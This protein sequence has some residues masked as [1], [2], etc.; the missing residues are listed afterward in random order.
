MPTLIST[1]SIPMLSPLKSYKSSLLAPP[2]ARHTVVRLGSLAA[3]AVLGMPL[4]NAQSVGDVTLSPVTVQDTRDREQQGYQGGKTRVGKTSQLA[5]DVPQSVTIV[6][7]QLIRERNA[8][9]FKEALRNVAGLTF[10]AGEGG[11]IGDNIT[12]RGYSAVGDLFLDGI[13]DIAQYNRETFNLQ[14]IDVLRGSASMLFGRGSTGGIIN[15]VSKTANMVDANEVAFTLGSDSYKRL[16][17]DM[18]KV[19][20]PDLAFRLNTMGTKS[21]SFRDDVDQSRWG[22][23]PS[24]TWRAGRD[25]EITLA[26]YYLKNNNTPDFGVPFFQGRPLN[27][28]IERFYGLRDTDYQRTET[29]IATA[30]HTHLF[31][32]DSALRTTIRKA[33]YERDLRGTAPRLIGAPT[34]VSDITGVNRQR[35]ARGGTEHTLALQTD[36]T[37]KLALAGMSHEVLLGAEFLRERALRYTNSSTIANP[38]TNVGNPNSAP[39]LPANFNASFNRTGYNKYEGRTTSVY[40]QDTIA[41]APQWKLLLG[42]RFDSMKAD[43]AR[44]LPAG[45]LERGDNVWSWRTGVMYEPTPLATWYVSYGSSFNPSAEAYQLDNRTANTPPEKSRNLEAGAK[46][47]LLD[48]DMSVRTAIFRSEKTNER[49]TDVASPD[50]AVLSGRRHTDGIEFESVGRLSAAWEVFGNVAFMRAEVDEASADQAGTEGKRPI[51]T[52]SYTYSLWST[53]K[54]AKGW[55]VGGGLEGVGTRYANATNTAAVPSYKRVDALVEY[56]PKPYSIKLNVFNLFDE[57]YY[58]G[59]YSGHVLPGTPRTAQLTVSTKF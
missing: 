19:L 23:A 40:G 32:K 38:A 57:K 21:D 3:A 15:Q 45:P 59:V 50:V 2:S 18:N 6:S 53:Y 35:Q 8:D 12:L 41:F 24:L 55:K 29:N 27:V 34:V 17:L 25:D 58:E 33:D 43:Y 30:T 52:P 7:E 54:V 37:N 51:N 36:Y 44:P 31:S 10:N 56:S 48:G 47:E 20:T 5:K 26:Y 9:T 16:T 1:N 11:R 42:T 22:V 49:N 14:Q 4:A 39:P 46:W 13:R 28:P